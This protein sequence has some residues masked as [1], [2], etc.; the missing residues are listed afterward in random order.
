[1]T[2]FLCLYATTDDGEPAES[3]AEVVE[4][5]YPD[6][7]ISNIIHCEMPMP[8][9]VVKEQKIFFRLKE[10]ISDAVLIRVS[11]NEKYERN[12]GIAEDE[13]EWAKAEDL[14]AFEGVEELLADDAFMDRLSRSGRNVRK[15]MRFRIIWSE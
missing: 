15:S 13:A 5:V 6:R 12:L 10:G 1:M 4:A 2:G 14:Q 3:G 7:G 11:V 8:P 9:M